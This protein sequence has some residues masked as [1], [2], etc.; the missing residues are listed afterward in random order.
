MVMCLL[1]QTACLPTMIQLSFVFRNNASSTDKRSTIDNR[2]PSKSNH[3]NDDD[4]DDNDVDVGFVDFDFVFD[5]TDD[6]WVVTVV[7]VVDENN[8][9]R[10]NP[11]KSNGN[12]D[13]SRAV[14]PKKAL[15]AVE[16]PTVF[17][18]KYNI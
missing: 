11:R 5:D 14:P 18:L 10:K 7:V 8:L 17:I 3:R 6:D 2:E 13:D 1:G 16:V 15:L 9:Y 12:C 4:D